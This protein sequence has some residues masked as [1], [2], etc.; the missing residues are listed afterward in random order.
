MKIRLLKFQTRWGNPIN[1]NIILLKYIEI[2]RHGLQQTFTGFMNVVYLLPTKVKCTQKHTPA[3]KHTYAYI[4]TYTQICINT[5]SYALT[6]I[7]SDAY[8]GTSCVLNSLTNRYNQCDTLTKHS[9][10][11]PDKSSNEIILFLLIM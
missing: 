8:I 1:L 11:F 10:S 2:Y 6:L 7:H 4:C 9:K 5:W 3:H